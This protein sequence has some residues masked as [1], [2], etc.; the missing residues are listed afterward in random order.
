MMELRAR[1]DEN[2]NI[3]WAQRLEESGCRVLYGLVDYKVHSKICLITCQDSGKIYYIT[4]I[5]TGNYN[6]KTAKLYTDLSLITANPDI[7]ADAAAFFNDLQIAN[8]Q[9][10]YKRLWVAPGS[11]KSNLMRL[12]NRERMKA[13]AG[14]PGRITIKCNSITDFDICEQLVISS[15]SGVKIDLIVRGICC[16]LP[17]VARL[18]ENITV[19]SIVG[20][21]LEHARVFCFGEGPDMELYISSADL[22]T[23]NTQRRVEIACPVL[24]PRLRGR[25]RDMLDVMLRDN[26]KAR[27]QF[28]DGRY[29]RREPGIDP[30]INSQSFF[31]EQARLPPP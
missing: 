12:M 27:E 22:M 23:R 11:L 28:A 9:G 1:F 16:V 18:T 24:D 8:I 6:E 21:F 17:R 20:R 15:Q 19:V 29:V 31:A 13:L 5:G 30:V 3:D 26:V 10:E 14:Q 2:N 4:Q 25:L 7:G